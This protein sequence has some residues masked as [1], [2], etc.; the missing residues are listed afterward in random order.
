MASSNTDSRRKLLK[1]CVFLTRPPPPKQLHPQGQNQLSPLGVPGNS[2]EDWRRPRVYAWKGNAGKTS[3]LTRFTPSRCISTF[4]RKPPPTLKVRSAPLGT[5]TNSSRVFNNWGVSFL[6]SCSEVARAS[7]KQ[8][9]GNKTLRN[10]R[11]G[12]TKQVRHR[13]QSGKVS[14]QARTDTSVLLEPSRIQQTLGGN[15]VFRDLKSQG[16][17]DAEAWETS[18]LTHWTPSRG[19]PRPSPQTS[20]TTPSKR[21][22]PGERKQKREAQTTNPPTFSPLLVKALQTLVVCSRTTFDEVTHRRLDRG[23][24]PDCVG[25]T[26]PWFTVSV[27][28]APS[29]AVTKCTRSR[30]PTSTAQ[31]LKASPEQD[32]GIH[33][34]LA[35]QRRNHVHVLETYN[36]WSHTSSEDQWNSMKAHTWIPND[37]Y[38]CRVDSKR[39]HLQLVATTKEQMER[40]NEIKCSNWS[41]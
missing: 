39:H 1:S 17:V 25:H 19:S 41:R 32:S 22:A 15:W 26:Q 9:G 23:F 8:G 36:K 34:V 30:V 35:E 38:T 27:R 16:K 29:I 21:A 3:R 12:T 11:F 37:K 10:P 6:R 5:A 24:R 40:H 31:T 14:E 2:H 18:S 4:R 7:P 28:Y 20:R 33:T 13:P